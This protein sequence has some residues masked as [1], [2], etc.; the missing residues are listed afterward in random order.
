METIYQFIKDCQT[1]YLATMDG[2]QPRVRPFG[3]VCIY[4]GKLYICA[5]NQKLVSKQIKAN[6][7]IEIS[8]AAGDGR[9]L[10]LTAEA[11]TDDNRDA[12]QAML[13]AHP[14]I[15]QMYK[16]DDRLF[17]VYYLKNATGVICSFEGKKETHTF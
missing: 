1:F 12:R 10:R 14:G 11:I 7:K 6:P 3:A 15:Q 8:T 16:A 13:D 2:D 4:D 5:N 9:W 17:E